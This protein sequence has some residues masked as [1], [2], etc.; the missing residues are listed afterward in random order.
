MTA[1]LLSNLFLLSLFTSFLPF[2]VYV[3]QSMY[4]LFTCMCVRRALGDVLYHS[5]PH[6]LEMFFTEPE[7]GW[8]PAST[9]SS[10]YVSYQCWCGPAQLFCVGPKDLNSG[11]N[12]CAVSALTPVLS[13]FFILNSSSSC[14]YLPSFRIASIRHHS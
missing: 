3:C 13:F 6:S 11:S 2:C 14:L 1:R 9:S 7:L 4:V 5:P 12:A 8:Q 10:D